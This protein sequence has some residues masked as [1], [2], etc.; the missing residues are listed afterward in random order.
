MGDDGGT[1]LGIRVPQL[2]VRHTAVVKVVGLP[3]AGGEDLPPGR[4]VQQAA[5]Q[6]HRHP[7]GVVQP[8]ETGKR[9]LAEQLVVV[10]RQPGGVKVRQPPVILGLGPQIVQAGFQGLQS[11]G[12]VPLEK[13]PPVQ[14]QQ[15]GAHAG[16]VVAW[17]VVQPVVDLAVFQRGPEEAPGPVHGVADPQ[18]VVPPMAGDIGVVVELGV[19]GLEQQVGVEVPLRRGADD[20]QLRQLAVGPCAD[21]RVDGLVPF[22]PQPGE[23]TV[24]QVVHLPGLGQVGGL[25]DLQRRGVQVAE[26]AVIGNVGEA[27]GGPPALLEQAALLHREQ[28]AVPVLAGVVLSV[29]VVPVQPAAANHP[30]AGAAAQIARLQAGEQAL[31]GDMAGGEGEVVMGRQVEVVGQGEIDRATGGA[32]AADLRP[33]EPGL[34]APVDGELQVGGV[35]D[36]DA[37]YLDGRVAGRAGAGF[38]IQLQGFR[39]QRPLPLPGRAVAVPG[40]VQVDGFVRVAGDEFRAPVNVPVVQHE[41]AG[42]QAGATAGGV[43]GAGVPPQQQPRLAQFHIAAQAAP[44][45]RPVELGL[46]G[47]QVAVALLGVDTAVQVHGVAV[48]PGFL[49]AGLDVRCRR[50][51]GLVNSRKRVVVAA[52]AA[53]HLCRWLAGVRGAGICGLG[54]GPVE[55]SVG[56]WAGIWAG[57]WVGIWV[58]IPV[59]IAVWR[60]SRLRGVFPG[61]LPGTAILG[62]G[63]A[64]VQHH[65]HPEG[66]QP[67]QVA[68]CV[69]CA[70]PGLPVCR[71]GRVQCSG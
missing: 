3:H 5:G 15:G 20:G 17:L 65:Q 24:P 10:E 28:P 13:Q 42:G 9:G 14:A 63:C 53:R 1:A 30:V 50:V 22:H 12:G 23:P 27:D 71:A 21:V 60:T 32:A 35:G 11:P 31:V 57:I 45:L 37:L 55:V 44:A 8:V 67:P 25:G 6:A 47:P 51:G 26:I 36:R 61:I 7:V 29:L 2:P 64:N 59:E 18:A 62:A 46:P 48:R 33:Q 68:A 38:E 58:G 43:D 52:T 41:L 66:A 69:R 4:R 54:G 49:G 34:A 16:G 40:V 39:P 19:V 70:R 56:I